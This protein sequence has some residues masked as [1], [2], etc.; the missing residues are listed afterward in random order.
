[1]FSSNKTSDGHSTRPTRQLSERDPLSSR[2]LGEHRSEEGLSSRQRSLILSA[3]GFERKL[4][5]G[6]VHPRALS[7]K[8]GGSIMEPAGRPAAAARGQPGRGR[9]ADRADIRS[10]M[11]PKRNCPKAKRATQMENGCFPAC[12]SLLRVLTKP[13]GFVPYLCDDRPERLGRI[14]TRAGFY[15][16]VSILVMQMSRSAGPPLC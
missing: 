16:R 4:Q 11:L 1:M 8:P 10:P 13:A 2:L 3:M 7:E 9:T 6:S 14:V 5:D 15:W 12:C